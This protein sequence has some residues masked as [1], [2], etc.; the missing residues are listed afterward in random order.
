[1]LREW[2]SY[3][4]VNQQLVSID[5]QLS[6]VLLNLP[7]ATDDPLE[8][9]KKRKHYQG[10][11]DY[12]KTQTLLRK[13][14]RL[15]IDITPEKNPQWWYKLSE[16]GYPILT[17]SGQIRVKKLI[18]DEK[19]VRWERWIKLAAPIITALTGLVGAFIGLMALLLNIK[20]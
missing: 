5:K 10:A 17:K 6:K 4:R 2:R 18:D 12:L 15:S 13:A 11:L 19:F 9:L 16:A 1:M 14:D 8:L 3:R 20:R 7:G